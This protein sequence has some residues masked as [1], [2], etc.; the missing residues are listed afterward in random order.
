MSTRT[1]LRAGLWLLTFVSAGQGVWA[2]LAP[3]SFYND[4]PTVSM[5]PPFSE[6]FV[7]DFGGLQLAMT[8]VMGSLGAI[9]AIPAALLITA[10]RATVPVR[11][12]N[13]G[14]DRA[15]AKDRPRSGQPDGR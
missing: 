8:I 13:V 1:W 15:S 12:Q 11:R 6:H 9:A 5:Y 3:R 7:S 2:Y 10:V 14:W 4:V